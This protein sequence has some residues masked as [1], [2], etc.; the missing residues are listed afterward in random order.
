MCGYYFDFTREIRLMITVKLV[1]GLLVP[2]D[3]EAPNPD[4]PPKQEQ[5][6][7]EEPKLK[8]S[9]EPMGFVQDNPNEWTYRAVKS[10]P[11]EFF[12]NIFFSKI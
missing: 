7:H 3:T 4:C 5:N 9:A 6:S 2:P 12:E 10:V 1:V 11:P 8:F